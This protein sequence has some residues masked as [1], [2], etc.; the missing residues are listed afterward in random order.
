MHIRP[1]TL[2]DLA[3]L[4]VLQ[5]HYVVNTHIT[6]DL[7]PFT[8][9]GREPW[10]REHSDGRRYRLLVA[11]ESGGG[12]LGYA[13]TGR[14][15]TK[16]AYDPTVESSIACAPGATGRGVGT[17]LYRAL[18]R[19]IEGEDIHRIDAGIAQPNDA[20]NA[21]HARFGFRAVGRFTAVGR[22]FGKYWDVLWME[23]PLRLAPD[24]TR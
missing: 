1:A 8:P 5:N 10:F 14:F 17:E 22:K 9:A 12:I 24:A 11:E 16:A 18:F 19:A 13:C 2:A 4:T 6:F 21:L 3:A 7:L 23:R 20:S 15:R